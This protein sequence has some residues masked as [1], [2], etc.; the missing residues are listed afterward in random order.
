MKKTLS[1][2]KTSEFQRV[3]NR[4]KWFG[5]DLISIYVLPNHMLQSRIGIAVGK[6]IGKANKRNRTKRVIRAAYQT[7]KSKMRVGYDLLFVWR[8]K[9]I[10]EDLNYHIILKDMEKA[11]GKAGILSEEK[12]DA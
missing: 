7:L 5:G 4:G 11:F 1:L 8:S 2:K 9:A 3:F 10:F 6:K 12:E